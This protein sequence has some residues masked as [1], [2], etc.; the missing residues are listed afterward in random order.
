MQ[1]LLGGNYGRKGYKLTYE[2]NWYKS[3]DDMTES[4][5]LN[6]YWNH[7]I[8]LARIADALRVTRKDLIEQPNRFSVEIREQVASLL[9]NQADLLKKGHEAKRNNLSTGQVVDLNSYRQ[10]LR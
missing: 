6:Q 4:K 2:T 8:K 7:E 9:Q 1:S 5:L 3:V 10:L